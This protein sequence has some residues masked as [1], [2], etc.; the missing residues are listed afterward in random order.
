LLG[1]RLYGISRTSLSSAT[2]RTDYGGNDLVQIGEAF[3]RVG[4]GLF[5]DFWIFFP[6]SIADCAIGCSC[7][8]EVDPGSFEG[9]FHNN[10]SGA[11]R[12][13]LSGFYLPNS[14]DSNARFAG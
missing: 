6:N 7:N 3:D 1:A 5:V 10:K 12:C 8:A 4:K 13:C 2:Y 14:D 9:L 11:P